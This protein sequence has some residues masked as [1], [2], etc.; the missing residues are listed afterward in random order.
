MRGPA[1]QMLPIATREHHDDHPQ[2]LGESSRALFLRQRERITNW[3][4]LLLLLSAGIVW[5]PAFGAQVSEVQWGSLLLKTAPDAEAVEAL[6][7]TT[8]IRAQVTGSVARVYVTQQF[9]NPTADWVE[10]LY[11]FPL[12]TN[13]AVDE[14]LMHVGERTI[15]GEIERREKA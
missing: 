5:P 14:L 4:A 8:T 15:R 9:T 6:R 7:V 12:A 2:S 10:G 11:V 13:A 1:G 3:L